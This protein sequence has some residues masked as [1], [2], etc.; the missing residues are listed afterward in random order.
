MPYLPGVRRFFAARKSAPLPYDAEV[1]WVERDMSLAWVGGTSSNNNGFRLDEYVV[2][3]ETCSNMSRRMDVICSGASDANNAMMAWL[4]NSFGT[5]FARVGVWCRTVSGTKDVAISF[6]TNPNTTS[7]NPPSGEFH[8]YSIVPD[9]NGTA[10]ILVDDISLGTIT[11]TST[12]SLRY[13]GLLYKYISSTSGSI[14]LK[15]L[16]L[17]SDVYLIPVKKG[18]QVGFYN[19]VDGHVFLEEQECLSAGP[20]V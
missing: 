1:E 7:T 15:H 4:G 12:A 10:E 5:L 19:M 11:T 9:G 8:K 18:T 13:F 6:G 14:R 17:G 3:D 20:V 16:R 2:S